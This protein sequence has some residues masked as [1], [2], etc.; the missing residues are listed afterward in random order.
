MTVS[1]STRLGIHRWTEDTDPWSRADWDDDNAKLEAIAIIGTQGLAAARPAAGIQRRLYLA[2]DTE[3]V[4]IDDGDE[5]YELI[6][7]ASL[8]A[9]DAAARTG[10]TAAPGT[11]LTTTTTVKGALDNLGLRTPAT[12]ITKQGTFTIG[13]GT[14]TDRTLAAYVANA[15]N[16]AYA[17]TPA[18]LTSAA[19]LSDLNLVRAAYENLRLY[20]EDL[21]GIVAGLVVDLRAVGIIG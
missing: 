11:G 2:T 19:Q 18:A 8:G 10:Y 6:S 4:F 9:S 16:T 13:S 1:L 17:G 21:A 7:E 14:A 3:R 5:W 20:T 12:A 15:Q